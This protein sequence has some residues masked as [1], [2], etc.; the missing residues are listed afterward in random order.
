MMNNNEILSELKHFHDTKNVI[1]A[2]NALIKE[3]I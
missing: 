3:T 1:A 2:E